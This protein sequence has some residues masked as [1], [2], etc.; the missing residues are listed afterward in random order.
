MKTV[1]CNHFPARGYI[2]LT[3][4]PFIFVRKSAERHYT[5][6]VS[7]HEHIHG[8][9]Q[10]EMLVLP[11]LLLYALEYLVR[12]LLYASHKEAY[13]NISFEQEAYINEAVPDY[14]A[15]RHHY[16]WAKHLFT[17]TYRHR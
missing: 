2:A 1:F 13:R 5:L 3:L 15:H 17:K 11:M 6:T 7:N 8:E 14:L 4:W 9:Q 16:A 12:L 10:K